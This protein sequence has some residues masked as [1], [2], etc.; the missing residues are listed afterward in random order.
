FVVRLR[1]RVIYQ[2]ETTQFE[3]RTL[4]FA[5]LTFPTDAVWWNKPL[6]IQHPHPVYWKST[7]FGSE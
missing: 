7:E 1:T 2:L 5:V 6:N 3:V 4:A